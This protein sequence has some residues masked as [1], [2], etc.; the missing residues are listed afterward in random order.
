VKRFATQLPRSLTPLQR[1][2]AWLAAAVVV[3]LAFLALS[4]ETHEDLHCDAHQPEHVCAIT[5]FAQGVTTPLA[6][7]TL[8]VGVWRLLH[9]ASE[10]RKIFVQAPAFIHLPGRAPPAF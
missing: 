8:A 10:G 7:V 6:A 3:M 9:A 2:V 5:L 4:P 1:A